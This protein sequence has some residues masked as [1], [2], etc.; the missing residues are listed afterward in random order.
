MNFR[1]YVGKSLQKLV[2]TGKIGTE[3]QER[4]E[5]NGKDENCVGFCRRSVS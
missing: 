1:K 4:N 5:K 3:L 2:K